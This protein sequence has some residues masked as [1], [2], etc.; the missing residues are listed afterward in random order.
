MLLINII[1]KQSRHGV[2][3]GVRVPYD[4]RTIKKLNYDNT[5]VV[6][7]RSSLRGWYKSCW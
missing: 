2:G 5:V 1:I 7:L 6:L 4:A 3:S